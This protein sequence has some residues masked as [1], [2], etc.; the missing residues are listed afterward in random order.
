MQKLRSVR[1]IFR[2]KKV[3]EGAGVRL[4]RMFGNG[5]VPQFDP[6]LL[7]DHFES[8]RPSDY[9][10]GFPWHPHRG[11]E[12]I[13]YVL[14][15]RVEH[16]DSL[17]NSGVIRPGGVQWM[18]AGSGIIHQEMPEGDEKNILHGFQLWANLPAKD[19]MNRPHYREIPS[20]RIP[21]FHETNGSR[22][23]I[24]AGEIDSVKGPVDGIA[25]DPVF[26]DVKLPPDAEFIYPSPVNATFFAV[27]YRGSGN[28]G[29]VSNSLKREN[30]IVT[31]NGISY[32][33][34]NSA[35]LFTEGSH[36]AISTGKEPVRFLLI[37]GSPLKEP[38]AWYGPIAM[39]TEVELTTAFEEFQLGTFCK[40][41]QPV[42]L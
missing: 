3:T 5:E 21:L 31:E 42:M 28:F 6:F 20:S 11:I 2:G 10:K 32:I 4:T 16:S 7:C 24:I 38:V 34:E 26:F 39:N 1:K 13:T 17:G 30:D 23:R 15:G 33:G 22:Y 29:M 18:T 12:T 36:L 19:K 8:D 40:H 27:V 14:N 41:H 9:S 37:G 25:T 35:V